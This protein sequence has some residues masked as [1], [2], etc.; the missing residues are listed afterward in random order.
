V[1]ILF[2]ALC[3]LLVIVGLLG[4]YLGGGVIAM[5]VLAFGTAGL[6]ILYPR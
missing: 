5:M 6:T 1:K 2:E 4:L 3:Y